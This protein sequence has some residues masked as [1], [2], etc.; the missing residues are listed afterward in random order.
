MVVGR[1]E[2]GHI[3]LT[4]ALPAEWEGQTVK[5][6]PFTPDDALPDAAQCLQILHAMGPMEYE[7]GEQARIEKAVAT[8]NDI[9]RAQMQSLADGLP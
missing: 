9:S 2:H 1:V 5:I 3:Q 4:S 6:E 7:S 8:M